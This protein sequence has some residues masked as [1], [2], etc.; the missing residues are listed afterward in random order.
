MLIQTYNSQ[1]SK[2]LVFYKSKSISR[3]H[4]ANI[5]LYNLK[6]YKSPVRDFRKQYEWYLCHFPAD[7]YVPFQKNC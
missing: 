6:S 5:T 1:F 3:G 4:I 2:A 7:V